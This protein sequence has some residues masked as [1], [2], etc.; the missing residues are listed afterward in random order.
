MNLLDLPAYGTYQH[1]YA[2]LLAVHD[3]L[4]T[5]ADDRVTTAQAEA[6]R[7]RAQ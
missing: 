2:E 6:S 4:I 5:A 3:A 1:T 7:E